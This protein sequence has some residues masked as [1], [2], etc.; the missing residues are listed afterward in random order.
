MLTSSDRAG[1]EPRSGSFGG[2]VA[3]YQKH[4]FEDEVRR[5]LKAWSNLLVSIVT[6]TA[7]TTVVRLRR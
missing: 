7:D 5:A 3:V 1:V 2:I 4:K 6:P